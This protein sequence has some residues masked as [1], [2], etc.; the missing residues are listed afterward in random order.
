MREKYIDTLYKLYEYCTTFHTNKI[1]SRWADQKEGGYTY[2][3]FKYQCDFLSKKLT[4]YGIGAGDKVAILSQNMPNWTVALFSLVPFGRIAV[5]I[6]PGSSENEIT[7]ILT[8][9]DSKALFISKRMLP[10]LN[11]NFYDS[12]V[13]IIDIETFEP[14]HK[15]DNAFT[16]DGRVQEP[17]PEDIATI[18]YTSGTTGNAKGVVLSHR[19]LTTCIMASY[20]ACKRNSK[21]IWLSILPMPHTYELTLGVLYPMFCGASVYYMSKPPAPSHLV[22]VMKELRPTTILTV[23]LI[24]EKIYKNSVLPTIKKSPT[25]SWMN[26]NMNWLLYKIIGAKL[27][28]TFGGRVTFFGIGGAKLDPT[29][30]AFLLKANF[31]YAIG[32]GLTETSPLLSHSSYRGRT[33]GSIGVPVKGTELKLD[34]VNPE[35]GE[36]EIIARGNNVMLG[37]YKDPL[38]TKSVLSDDGWFRTNDLAVQDEKGRYFIKGRLSNMILGPSGENIYPEEI[39]KVINDF[40]DISESL[41]VQRNGRLVALVQLNE[42]IIDWNQEAEDEI[43]EKINSK[44]EAIL[45]YVNKHVSKFSKVNEVEVMKEPFEKTATQKIRRFK[46]TNDGAPKNT[47]ATNNKKDASNDLEQVENPQTQKSTKTK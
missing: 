4:Q 38:R 44:K 36:G 21:D 33:P 5:P 27:R 39:E 45:N 15:D 25:L 28:S 22:K 46:Y 20:D 10:K 19:N 16:C 11:K 26:K 43:L 3:E 37:Y 47:E 12:M 29:V 31:P 7:N 2:G 23:P 32:Y 17:M 42:N 35:T 14:I 34:N 13:L 24:I 8:H 40:E 30:E 1:H 9:S 18:I 41:V 6:L